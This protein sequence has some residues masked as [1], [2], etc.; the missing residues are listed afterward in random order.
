MRMKLAIATFLLWV[1]L[2]AI[3][4]AQN[5]KWT[6]AKGTT[7]Y[8]DNIFHLPKNQVDISAFEFEKLPSVQI[9]QPVAPIPTNE[10]STTIAQ[11]QESRSLGPLETLAFKNVIIFFEKEMGIYDAMINKWPPSIAKWRTLCQSVLATTP[12]KQALLRDLP[13]INNSIPLKIVE[14]YLNESIKNDFVMSKWNNLG[15]RFVESEGE[16]IDPSTGQ[17]EIIK[18]K[19]PSGNG[20]T[21][22]LMHRLRTEEGQKKLLLLALKAELDIL[23]AP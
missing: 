7:N 10:H 21:Q 6:D 8:T 17:L 14:A 23:K 16:N 13:K 18:T 11:S 2:P 22:K 1:V 19:A 3:V 4:C 12:R 20:M 9:P 5:Y 15:N